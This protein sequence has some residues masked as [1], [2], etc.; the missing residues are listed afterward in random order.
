MAKLSME[1][2]NKLTTQINSYKIISRTLNNPANKDVA[3][4]WTNK[5]AEK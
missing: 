5:K 3:I 4:V 1:M 2:I